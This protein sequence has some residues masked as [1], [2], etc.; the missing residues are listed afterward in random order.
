MGDM[1]RWKI[2]KFRGNPDNVYDE[3]LHE[4]EQNKGGT[5]IMKGSD[6]IVSSLYI[7]IDI[8][9]SRTYSFFIGEPVSEN[10]EKLRK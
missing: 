1:W 6:R 7:K 9:T 10:I 5:F 3:L 4:N 8:L 2:W